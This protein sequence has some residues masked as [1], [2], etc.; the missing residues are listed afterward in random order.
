MFLNLGG[1]NVLKPLE[2]F[3]NEEAERLL[4]YFVAYRK[5]SSTADYFKCLATLNREVCFS[6]QGASTKSANDN[7][8]TKAILISRKRN[9]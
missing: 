7:D 9:A 6:D 4:S 5:L 2:I 8:L 1:T 3:E